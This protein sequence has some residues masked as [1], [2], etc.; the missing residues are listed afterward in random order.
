MSIQYS[1]FFLLISFWALS[2][3]GTA[4]GKKKVIYKSHTEIDFSG[5]KIE[6]K[7]KSP[8]VFYIFQR[9]RSL[10]HEAARSPADLSYH[11]RPMKKILKEM[12][13]E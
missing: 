9:K 7:I 6:G 3:Q 11:D 12:I 8:A 5:D 1:S 2:A 10:G 13:K 4:E